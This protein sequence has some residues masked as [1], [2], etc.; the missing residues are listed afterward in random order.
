MKRTLS[1]LLVLLAMS[2]PAQADQPH[3]VTSIHPLALVVKEIV[4]DD[5]RVST[6]VP[7]DISP[8]HY[9]M[10]PSERRRLQ[11]AERFVWLGPALEPFLAGPLDD[12]G[13]QRKSLALDDAEHTPEQDHGT[14]DHDNHHSHGPG[15][16][17][18]HVWLNPDIVRSMLPTLVDS[19][20][21]LEGLDRSRL[22]ANRRDFLDRL[23]S[24]EKAIRERISGLPT[25]DVFTYH[26]AFDYFA[27]HFDVRIAGTLTV[28]PERNPGARHLAELQEKLRTAESPCLM[29]EPQF[30]TDWWEGLNIGQPVGVSHWDPLGAEVGIRPG[31]YTRFLGQLADALA[32]CRP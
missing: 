23:A 6:L 16:R 4:R 30:G 25:M 29:T 31:G 27:A 22:E 10:R 28:N 5:A 18:P 21:R 1:T 3:I 17:D 2:L 20:S 26:G 9:S 13:L 14:H 19:L 15:Q 11:Q 8:H 12:P 7:A 24:T 32:S